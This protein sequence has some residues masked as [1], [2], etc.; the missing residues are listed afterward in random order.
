MAGG[1]A[2][3]E[4]ELPRVRSSLFF[5][6]DFKHIT[7]DV[8]GDTEFFDVK[9]YPWN[10]QGSPE[11]FAAASK[12]HVLICRLQHTAQP[13]KNPCEIIRVIRDDDH[14]ALDYSCTWS[15]DAKTEA[16]LLCIGG[17]GN[18]VKVYDVIKGTLAL[19]LAGHGDG[20]IDLITSPANPLIIASASDDTT[21]RIWSLD[22]IHSEQPCVGIL[23][24]ENHSWYLLSIAFHQTGRYILSAG[25]DRVISMWTLPDF[26]NQHME[27]PIVV[28]YPHFLTNEIHPNLIDCVSFYGDNVLSRACHEDCIVMW[29]IEGFSSHD[30]PPAA[31]DAPT[32]YD[33]SQLTR[34]SFVRQTDT[35]SCPRPYTR[36]MTFHTKGCG[37]QFYMRFSMLQRKGMHPVLAFGNAGSKIMFWDMARFTAYA[38]YIQELDKSEKEGSEEP[39]RPSWLEPRRQQR[40]KPTVGVVERP[41]SK[42][43]T[44][45]SSSGRELRREPTTSRAASSARSTPVE[46][47]PSVTSSRELATREPTGPEARTSWEEKYGISDPNEP[48]KPHKVES[49][50]ASA[51]LARQVAW[52]MDGAWCVVAGSK[53]SV[54][55][56]E[57]WN[58]HKKDTTPV[59][60]GSHR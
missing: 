6:D 11:I 39:K 13:N 38:D 45:T 20:I 49:F 29:R 34:S 2:S 53:N 47:A 4:W 37:V 17:R 33:P 48:I 51:V 1:D 27:R 50:S 43:R 46:T 59:P 36:L 5:E 10:P 55:I 56:L 32:N 14:D 30:P 3:G 26:P 35:K 31:L 58:P 44:E 41:V 52:S 60:K 21:A 57:R 9:F 19:T 8:G 16:P 24:G 40:K 18:N 7:D 28:Y 42:L 23:G 12:K 22:P 54:V 15:R 25:H